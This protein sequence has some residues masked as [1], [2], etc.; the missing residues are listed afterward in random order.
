MCISLPFTF[1]C[2]PFVFVKNEEVRKALQ[3]RRVV[4][5]HN[6]SGKYRFN[7]ADQLRLELIFFNHASGHP[8]Q[9]SSPRKE[10]INE[11]LAIMGI[12]VHSELR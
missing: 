12:T 2:R 5:K 4:L 9:T 10:V 1:Q 3:I 11:C 7:I 8:F 6:A